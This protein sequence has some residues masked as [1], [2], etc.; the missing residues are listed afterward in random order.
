M[1]VQIFLLHN[2]RACENTSGVRQRSCGQLTDDIDI[3]FGVGVCGVLR[4]TLSTSTLDWF[5][6]SA[7]TKV[8]RIQE[9]CFP[10]WLTFFTFSPHNTQPPSQ[11]YPCFVTSE[12]ISFSILSIPS[13]AISGSHTQCGLS[14]TAFTDDV[15]SPSR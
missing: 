7:D 13:L 6:D 10:R 11:I 9:L 12:Q 2:C 15:I 3:L 1:P 14:D 4:R 8:A 5:D